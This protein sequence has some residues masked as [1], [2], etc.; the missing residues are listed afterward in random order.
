MQKIEHK[1]GA[2]ILMHLTLEADLRM[3]PP[4]PFTR[5]QPRHRRLHSLVLRGQF[6][7]SLVAS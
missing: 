1:N 5:M 7:F 3:E 6:L 4:T 2:A